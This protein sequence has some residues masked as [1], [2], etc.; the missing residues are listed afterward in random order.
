[1][2]KDIWLV[3]NRGFSKGTSDKGVEALGDSPSLVGFEPTDVDIDPLHVKK[4]LPRNEVIY[5]TVVED[6]VY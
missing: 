4:V 5:A 1:M 3:G 2:G 6:V